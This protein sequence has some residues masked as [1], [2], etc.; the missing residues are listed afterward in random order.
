MNSRPPPVSPTI[1]RTAYGPTPRKDERAGTRSA[2][3][4]FG[5]AD[6]TGRRTLRC[7]TRVRLSRSW[8]P[9]HLLP[10]RAVENSRMVN[11]CDSKTSG[12]DPLVTPMKKMT[13]G[14]IGGASGRDSR[15]V[16]VPRG[17]GL[18]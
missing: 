1:V 8:T 18:G 13:L 12:V 16:T 7:T 11:S 15:R 3:D 14:K 6:A 4:A 10:R 17:T 2:G 9:V 5:G